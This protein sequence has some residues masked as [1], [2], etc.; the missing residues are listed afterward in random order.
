M[1][2]PMKMN[3]RPCEALDDDINTVRDPF[4]FLQDRGD[5]LRYS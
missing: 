3:A 1:P 5:H 4:L 2:A